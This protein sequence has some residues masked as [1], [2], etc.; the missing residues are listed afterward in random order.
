[1][2]FVVLLWCCILF[3]SDNHPL[4]ETYWDWKSH[5]LTLDA[6]VQQILCCCEV[7]LLQ[8]MFH[9]V[10]M[11]WRVQN[12]CCR[13]YGVWI[14]RVI[15]GNHGTSNTFFFRPRNGHLFPKRAEIQWYTFL[16]TKGSFRYITFIPFYTHPFWAVYWVLNYVL[17][18]ILPV[19]K[20]LRELRYWQLW[21]F[22]K[23]PSPMWIGK[24]TWRR[25][26]ALR[27]V[28]F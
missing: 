12:M 23:C 28:F 22:G 18:D 26:G 14:M 7:Q 20:T 27:A 1:M 19:I 15:L 13:A 5:G 16:C 21:S 10:H 25:L 2:R 17:R 6:H 4:C 9:I 8:V 11:H 3:K 24:P